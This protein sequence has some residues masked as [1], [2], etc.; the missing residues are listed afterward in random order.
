MEGRRDAANAAGHAQARPEGAAGYLRLS[1]EGRL[2]QARHQPQGPRRRAHLRQQGVRVRRPVPPGHAR[3]AEQRPGARRR[4]HARPAQAGGLRGVLHRVPHA[5]LHRAVDRHEPLDAAARLLP[6]RQEG[7][8]GAQPPDQVAVP[9]G[10]P[11]YHRLLGL[12]TRAE[13]GDAAPARL[14]RVPVRHQ[15]AARA[16]AVAP[17]AGTAGDAP[18]SR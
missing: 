13:A 10:R 12:R 5:K 11:L 3:H 4:G 8:P 7:G 18:T 14:E 6:G 9:E 15:P 2:R 16:D 1:E 17:T